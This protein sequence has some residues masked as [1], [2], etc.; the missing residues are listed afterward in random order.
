M[1]RGVQWKQACERKTCALLCPLPAVLAYLATR[2]IKKPV[3]LFTS[4]MP[5][6]AFGAW[7]P[8][9]AVPFIR[10]G[11]ALPYLLSFQVAGVG[12]L[13]LDIWLPQV[14]DAIA[15]AIWNA[16]PMFSYWT[17]QRK[18]GMLSGT[19]LADCTTLLHARSAAC[20]AWQL[21]SQIL[22]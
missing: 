21:P 22:A 14:A 3:S 17:N 15:K 16:S 10:P 7:V 20:C 2:W 9:L 18:A 1:W 19:A 11:Q 8:V 12:L 5:R 4:W 13:M 6:Y